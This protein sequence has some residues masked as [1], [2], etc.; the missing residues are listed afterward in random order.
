MTQSEVLE[1]RTITDEHL[2]LYGGTP[3]LYGAPLA[4]TPE[5]LSGADVAFLGIRGKLR[6]HSDG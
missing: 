1:H 5:D 3:T 6:P 2:R 4:L